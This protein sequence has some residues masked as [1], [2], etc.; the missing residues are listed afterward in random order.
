VNRQFQPAKKPRGS[1]SRK[2]PAKK[3]AKR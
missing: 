1:H 2:S 3:S